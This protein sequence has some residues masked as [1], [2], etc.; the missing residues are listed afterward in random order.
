MGILSVNEYENKKL[1]AGFRYAG[2][3]LEP[4]KPEVGF[5]NEKDNK[6]NEN[7]VVCVNCTDNFFRIFL[8]EQIHDKQ[9]LKEDPI[10]QD[11]YTKKVYMHL[12]KEQGIYYCKS[13]NNKIVKDQDVILSPKKTLKIAGRDPRINSK[14]K[15]DFF[16][17]VER[18]T[19]DQYEMQYYTDAEVYSLDNNQF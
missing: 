16:Q 12:D 13:C 3:E 8:A 9:D 7:K 19:E 1:N 4:V 17:A 11:I 18:E 6:E 10:L 5:V 14:D 2:E 15:Q